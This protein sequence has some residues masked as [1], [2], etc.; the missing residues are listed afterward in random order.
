MAARRLKYK[1]LYLLRTMER[2]ITIG[3]R[4]FKPMISRS[5]MDEAVRTVAQR[6]NKDLEKDCP[7]FLCILNGSF[8]FAADLLRQVRIDCEVSFVKVS[9]YAG[10][11]SVGEVTEL[12]GLKESVAGRTVVIVEDI[13]DSG[14]TVSRIAALLREKGAAKTLVATA[15]F[16]KQVYRG[17][18]NV[19]YF[20]FEIGNEFVVGYGLD[21][22]GRGRNLDE[23]HVL[24]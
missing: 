15:L 13:V 6:I 5:R 3:D 14:I 21:Y 22:N 24:A 12:I 9:S 8:I 4:Q 23:I 7:L 11:S 20:C 19:D 1:L 2:I 18:L 10:T 17:E 16:K